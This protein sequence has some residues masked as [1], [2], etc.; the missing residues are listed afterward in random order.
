MLRVAFCRQLNLVSSSS[1]AS[2]LCL[3]V[4]VSSVM[5]LGGRRVHAP[6]LGSSN[7]WRYSVRQSEPSLPSPHTS[8][9]A[10]TETWEKAAIASRGR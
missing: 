7:D 9:D 5:S 4:W 1:W 6:S 8:W 10:W 2:L 3:A